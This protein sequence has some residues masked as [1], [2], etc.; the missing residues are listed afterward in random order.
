VRNLGRC[1]NQYHCIHCGQINNV[2]SSD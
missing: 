2:D 1:Y